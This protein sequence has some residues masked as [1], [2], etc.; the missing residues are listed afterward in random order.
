[1]YK[2]YAT[3]QDICDVL[4]KYK[5]GDKVTLLINRSTE[6]G[7]YEAGT[8]MIIKEISLYKNVECSKILKDELRNYNVSER[9]FQFQLSLSE[10]DDNLL[11]CNGIQIEKGTVAIQ[12]IK[13]LYKKK[14]RSG[15]DWIFLIITILTVIFS[16]IVFFKIL[17]T[18]DTLNKII[19]I[20]AFPICF[21]HLVNLSIKCFKNDK[22]IIKKKRKKL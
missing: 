21:W 7:L 17:Q 18:E 11:L 20:V 15:F 9:V 4:C 10:D 6:Q 19:T 3:P 2:E 22:F 14:R 12:D 13:Q 16:I 1:M 8:E 5:I